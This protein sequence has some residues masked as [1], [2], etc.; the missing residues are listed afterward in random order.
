MTARSLILSILLSAAAFTTA[1]NILIKGKAHVSYGGKQIHL[2]AFKDY[3]TRFTEK[4]D[5]DT[6]SKNGEF[7]LRFNTNHTTPLLLKIDNIV[8]T[9]Y[10]QPDYVYAVTIPEAEKS[11]EY[12]NEAEL[13]I[14]IGIIGKDST[15]LN[16]LL[17]DYQAQVDRYFG[18]ADKV[19]INRSMMFKKADSLKLHC[20]ERYKN[21]KN[22][23]F[24][25]YYLYNIATINASVSRGEKFLI[26]NFILNKK[27]QY[28]HSEYMSF[29]SACFSNYLKNIASTKKGQTLFHI[30]NTEASVKKLDEFVKEDPLLKN[31]TL[32]E[33]VMIQNLWEFNFSPQFNTGAVASML[34][35]IHVNT[36]VEK[37]KKITEVMLVFMNNLQQGTKA[38]D[39]TFR[40][41]TGELQTLSSF[42]GHWIYL[43][44]FSTKHEPSLKEMAKIAQIRKKMGDKVSFVSICLDDSVKE[45]IRYLKANPKYDWTIVF[46]YDKRITT[47]AK[48]TYMVKGSEAYF[49]INNQFYFSQSP[50]NSPS[51][52]IEYRLNSIFRNTRKTTKT[53][54]R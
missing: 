46:N 25:S 48:N 12:G 7:E 20:D 51:G 38:P 35:D 37:H 43:N 8:S 2:L 54:I 29:F 9:L 34:S 3:I 19:Y 47:T 49:L 28:D 53:G 30:I 31:D 10:V 23:F 21:I 26:S 11:L 50:A 40:T 52:G 4:A 14:N 44:F 15:E 17:F 45:Y 27:I 22:E 18:N 36:T 39:C 16:A 13:P 5:T 24:K 42:K 6:I 32:R 41:K 1:Q 33:L